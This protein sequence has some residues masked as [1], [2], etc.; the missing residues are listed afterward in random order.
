MDPA[1]RAAMEEREARITTTIDVAAHAAKK[2][3]ALDAHASQA[4]NIFWLRLPPEAMDVVFTHETFIRA[5]DTT[6][7]SVPETDLFAGIRT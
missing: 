5:R 7:A 6:G 4:H 1:R 3:A 2:R